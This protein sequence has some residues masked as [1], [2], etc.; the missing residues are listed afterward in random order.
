[1]KLSPRFMWT[2]LALAIVLALLPCCGTTPE[3]KAQLDDNVAVAASYVTRLTPRLTTQDQSDGTQVSALRFDSK[4]TGADLLEYVKLN[5]R[6]WVSWS[7]IE[8]NLTKEQATAFLARYGI[9]PNFKE[10]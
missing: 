4:L 1:M 7:V 6:A 9:E 5:L 8:G 3:Q 10:D 2:I